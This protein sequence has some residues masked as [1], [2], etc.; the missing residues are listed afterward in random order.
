MRKR[1]KNTDD[2]AQ[3]ATR[4]ERLKQ[5]LR[6]NLVRRKGTSPKETSLK[7]TSPKMARPA[8]QKSPQVK[9]IKSEHG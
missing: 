1:P 9:P 5:A 2:K 8:A 6:A 4:Q 3:S 7:G